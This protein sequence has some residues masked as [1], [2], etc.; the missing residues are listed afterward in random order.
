MEVD[1]SSVRRS[2]DAGAGSAAAPIPV[3]EAIAELNAVTIRRL[4]AVYVPSATGGPAPSCSASPQEARPA[5]QRGTDAGVDAALT[6]LRALGSRL[7]DPARKA[8]AHPE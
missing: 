6:A 4:G 3:T 5:P 1:Q 2:L 8:L 7:S